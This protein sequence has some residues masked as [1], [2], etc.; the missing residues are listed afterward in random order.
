MA[1]QTPIRILLVEG[2]Q[3]VVSRLLAEQSEFEIVQA[4]RLPVAV[5]LVSENRLAGKTFD[6]LLID[7][8]TA[9]AA[10]DPL[11]EGLDAFRLARAL[12]PGIPI[13][14]VGKN[15]LGNIADTLILE[16]ALACLPREQLKVDQLIATLRQSVI[17]S[18][19][20]KRRFHMLFDSAPIGILLAV[21]RRVVMANPYALSSLGF[22]ESELFPLSV[23]ELFP[24]ESQSLIEKS[25]DACGRGETLEGNFI[26]DLHRHDESIFRCR[27]TVKSALLNDAPAVAI[28]LAPLNYSPWIEKPSVTPS[29]NKSGTQEISSSVTSSAGNASNANESL[30]AEQLAKFQ[31]MQALGRLAGGV[32]HDF[33]NLL[34]A[35]NGYSEH[36]L[37]IADESGPYAP[38]LKAIRRAGETA[39]EIS[40]RLHSFSYS[41]NLISLPLKV[42]E[43]LQKL[44][45]KIISLLGPHIE[46]RMNLNAELKTAKMDENQFEQ[47][48]VNLC[49]NAVEAM[50]HGGILTLNSELCAHT[51]RKSFTHLASSAKNH[52]V[53][54]VEDTGTGMLPTAIDSLCEPFFSTKRGGRGKG[55]GLATVYGILNQWNGG[56]SVTSIPGQGTRMQIFFADDSKPPM[57][58]A[59]KHSVWERKNKAESILIVDDDESLRD[60][61]RTVLER[62]GYSIRDAQSAHDALELMEQNPDSVQLV[63]TD[64]MLR[65]MGG[66]ELS[67]KLNVIKSALPIIFISGHPLDS[68]AEQG[69]AI[70]PDTFLEKPFTPTQLAAKVRSMLNF[71]KHPQ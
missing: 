69:I 18:Q 40:R 2:A 25:L 39:S 49:T 71:S 62:F 57:S 10:L 14:T 52:I 12:L 1:S 68:L 3:G 16:G 38:G 32:A 13:V 9:A 24:E 29:T 63:I 20:E 56:I 42:D 6:L 15:P 36:L 33:N 23:L 28:Y 59:L 67:Q 61:L 34:T 70:A 7:I 50:P 17:R 46:L 37:G 26:T 58:D 35:I 30:S 19:S 31:K 43:A 51:S 54:S 53:V 41:E 47:I 5:R 64:I 27:V 21:G 11:D 55:L 4:E 66:L 44:Q 65:G 8:V 60:M 48:I 45:P 22:V